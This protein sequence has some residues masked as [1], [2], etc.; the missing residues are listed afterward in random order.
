[1]N[2]CCCPYFLTNAGVSAAV[3][4]FARVSFS[5]KM[6]VASST[7]SS[8]PSIFTPVTATSPSMMGGS[9]LPVGL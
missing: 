6:P 3:S 9:P 8:K 7:V 5:L 2:R 4:S 1:M